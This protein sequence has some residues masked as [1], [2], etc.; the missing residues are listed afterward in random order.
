MATKKTKSTAKASVKKRTLNP[1]GGTQRKTRGAPQ[2]DLDP[3]RR[4]GNFEGAGEH[5]RKGG[6]TSG[7]VGQTT[8]TFRTNTKKKGT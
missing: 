4:L 2:T 3:K 6:R 1:P 8:K 7:I 5:P